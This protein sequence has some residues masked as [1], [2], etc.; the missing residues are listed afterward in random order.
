MASKSDKEI[1]RFDDKKA[2][3]DLAERPWPTKAMLARNYRLLYEDEAGRK[4]YEVGEGAEDWVKAKE[5]SY[6]LKTS[7][8]LWV[9]LPPKTTM[10]G[11]PEESAKIELTRDKLGVKTDALILEAST[12]KSSRSRGTGFVVVKHLKP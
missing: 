11:M 8:A 12:H 10:G 9:C 5:M 2:A 6:D 3:D 1:A 7:E 4:Y